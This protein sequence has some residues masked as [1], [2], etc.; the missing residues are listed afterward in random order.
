MRVNKIMH[1][2]EHN[3]VIGTKTSL[4]NTSCKNCFLPRI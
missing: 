2:K 1:A 3:T 4:R